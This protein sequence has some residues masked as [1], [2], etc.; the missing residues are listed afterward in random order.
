MIQFDRGTG[1]PPERRDAV[2]ML[3]SIIDVTVML[4]DA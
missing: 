4:P 2:L 3:D 1:P